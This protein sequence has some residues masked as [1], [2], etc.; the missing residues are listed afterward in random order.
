[1]QK[2]LFFMMIFPILFCSSVANVIDL[3][4]EADMIVFYK[5]G[6]Q[7]YLSENDQS[8]IDQLFSDAIEKSYSMPAFAVSIDN[9]TKKSMKSGLWI[10]FVFDKTMAASEMPFDSLLINITKDCHGINLIRGN[11]GIFEGRCYYLD[12]ENTMDDVYDFLID[13]TNKSDDQIEVELDYEEP[14]EVLIKEE[15]S[16]RPFEDKEGE[17]GGEGGKD[18][19]PENSRSSNEI[20]KHLQ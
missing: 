11:D 18:P 16:E 2:V 6:Q 13:C 10:E 4:C 17:D 19:L 12:L 7:I 15:E 20:L 14:Q 9:L 8:Q 5:E 3:F 1:M